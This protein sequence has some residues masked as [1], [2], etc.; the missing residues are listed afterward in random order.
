MVLDKTVTQVD[1]LSNAAAASVCASDLSS[2][3]PTVRVVTVAGSP[4]PC[5]GTH[6]LHTGLLQGLEVTRAKTKKKV[7]KI[8]YLFKD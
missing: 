4:C 7:L 5:G 8:S 6:V 1:F 3:P 2:Y